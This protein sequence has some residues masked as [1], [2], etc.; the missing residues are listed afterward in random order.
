ML[1]KLRNFKQIRR[2]SRVTPAL[3][4]EAG[5]VRMIKDGVKV[6]SVDLGLNKKN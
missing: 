5:I 1:C 6:L 3:M 2:W 4:V